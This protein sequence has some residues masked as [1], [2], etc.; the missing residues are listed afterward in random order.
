M[1]CP[2]GKA[3]L[4]L[5]GNGQSG[6]YSQNGCSFSYLAKYYCEVPPR[7]KCVM[8]LDRAQWVPQ[9]RQAGS[10]E[11]VIVAAASVQGAGDAQTRIDTVANMNGNMK[12][13]FAIKTNGFLIPR[14]ARGTIDTDFDVNV[15]AN[16]EMANSV[17][18]SAQAL[19]ASY[20]FRVTNSQDVTYYVWTLTLKADSGDCQGIT[21]MQI[22]PKRPGSKEP[23]WTLAR[24]GERPQCFA[25]ACS[26]P[27]KGCETCVKGGWLPPKQYVE[28]GHGYA[29]VKGCLHCGMT[30]QEKL[31]KVEEITQTSC[32]L[33]LRGGCGIK[34]QLAHQE[35]YVC[36]KPLHGP[37]P[38]RVELLFKAVVITQTWDCD[39]K[40]LRR[41]TYGL[42]S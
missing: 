7:E 5:H 14:G 21:Q 17:E 42:T 12:N 32:K 34:E 11:S 29:G 31:A 40:K 9:I 23:Y 33:G 41:I 24:S 18:F 28:D 25:G 19:A 8:R 3:L 4:K 37:P 13:K 20:S 22:R 30:W 39:T 26:N 1:G 36:G 35:K 16:L 10:T 2:T 6:S 38:A 27:Q 15:K